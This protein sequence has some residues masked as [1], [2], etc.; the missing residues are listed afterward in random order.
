MWVADLAPLFGEPVRGAAV[1]STAAPGPGCP[2]AAASRLYD[3]L[4]PGGQLL[5][6][7]DRPGAVP[8]PATRP[9]ARRPLADRPPADT[10]TD[11]MTSRVAPTF[12]NCVVHALQP[13]VKPARRIVLN[14]HW[15]KRISLSTVHTAALLRSNDAINVLMGRSN[16]AWLGSFAQFST[17]I[18]YSS[19]SQ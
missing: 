11:A 8:G 18:F 2:A 16:V 5:D 7:A 3:P 10:H 17:P 1:Q 19:L 12:Y 15:M 9:A 4:L 6:T 13:V 14:I